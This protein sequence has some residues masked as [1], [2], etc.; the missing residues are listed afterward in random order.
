MTVKGD[1]QTNLEHLRGLTQQI[2]DIQDDL[3]LQ[4]SRLSDLQD[5][6][7][8]LQQQQRQL[9]EQISASSRV[10]SDVVEKQRIEQEKL[11]LVAEQQLVMQRAI[12]VSAEQSA[13]DGR[14]RTLL[15]QA[16]EFR[17]QR[18]QALKNG[19]FSVRLM[20]DEYCSTPELV[21][22]YLLL[23][24]LDAGVRRS[25]LVS[26]G[27]DEIPDKEY[28]RD[29]MGRLS[30]ALESTREALTEVE[31]TDIAAWETL[32]SIIASTSNQVRVTEE[33]LESLPGR[34]AQA[35]KAKETLDHR[36]EENA[37]KRQK[38]LHRARNGGI[39]TLLLAITLGI[40]EI[41]G[42]EVV[43]HGT[44]WF[45]VLPGAYAALM[46]LLRNGLDE[47]NHISEAQLALSDL[48]KETVAA[49]RETARLEALRHILQQ[50]EQQLEAIYER[51]SE[52]RDFRL[53][54]FAG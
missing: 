30:T 49:P 17:R 16:A 23:R 48:E 43:M 35:R 52:L 53:P 4:Q 47:T 14:V 21:L 5:D 9:G 13:A 34:L 26:D 50:R 51:H 31:R 18:Q 37:P 33:R 10:F 7:D 1:L 25:E 40:I 45:L 8:N 3:V 6:Q 42:Y 19:F 36:Q 38:Y 46:L 15:L 41:L 2:T 32:P 44:L 12:A 20:L 24:S 39:V 29:V 54:V 22:R 28:A 11:R 27:L